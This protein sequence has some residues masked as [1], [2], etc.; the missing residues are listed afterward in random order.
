MPMT[1][2]EDAL[3]RNAIYKYWVPWKARRCRPT[4]Y[5]GFPGDSAPRSSTPGA[6]E[7]IRG[8]TTM[9]RG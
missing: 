3:P 6:G 1:D 2:A 8:L 9:R 7:K 5:L 4:C